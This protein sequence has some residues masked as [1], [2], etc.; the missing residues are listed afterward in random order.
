MTLLYMPYVL[1]FVLVE[2]SVCHEPIV[3]LIDVF[4]L[5][6]QC[7]LRTLLVLTL[8][9]CELWHWSSVVCMLPQSHCVCVFFFFYYSLFNVDLQYLQY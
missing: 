8:T 3:I 9:M 1:C 4:M 7:L 5:L 2:H 6:S